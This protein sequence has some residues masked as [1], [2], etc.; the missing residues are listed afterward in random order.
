[1]TIDDAPSARFAEKLAWLRKEK[2]PAVFFVWGEKASDTVDLLV[3]ALRAGY[4]LGNH[5]WTHPRFSDLDE[6][7]AREEITKTEALL[8]RVHREAGVEWERKYFRFPYFDSGGDGARAAAYQRMLAESGYSAIDAPPEVRRDTLCGFDQKEYWLGNAE[9]PDGL[10]DPASIM[11]R[12]V[13]GNPAS[14]SV[15]LIHD[16]EYSHDLFFA[17]IRRYR[18]LGVT[19]TVP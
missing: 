7:T 14:D 8:S 17:C 11:A 16:H 10:D 4:P 15:I 9:A 6:C 18:E 13:P 5:S 1:M 2:I 12:I 3:E 19:F